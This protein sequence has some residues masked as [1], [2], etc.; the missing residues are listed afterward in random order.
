MGLDARATT[1][2]VTLSRDFGNV[3]DTEC[4]RYETAITAVRNKEMSFRDFF[5]ALQAGEYTR[6]TSKN[7]KGQSFCEQ[8]M[9]SEED[10]VKISS[11]AE[12]EANLSKLKTIRIR[13]V[14]GGGSFSSGTKAKFKLSLPLKMTYTERVQPG[15]LSVRQWDP[16]R[17]WVTRLGPPSMMPVVGGITISTLTMYHP[18]P[19]RIENVQHDAVLSLNDPSDP[20]ADVIILI[21]LKASNSGEESVNFFSK[22]GYF[23]SRIQ[24]ADST[25]G[26]YPET[27]IPTG[28]DWGIN[29]VFWLGKAGS[30]NIAPVTDAFFTWTGASSFTRT[31]LY[32]NFVESRYGWVPEGKQVRYFMLQTPVSI[33]TTD[34]SFLTRSLPPTPSEEAIHTIPDPATA[35]ASKILYKK[36]T[37]D[38]A[39]AGCGIARERMSNPGTGDPM[40]PSASGGGALDM[41]IDATGRPLSDMNS[42]DPFKANASNARAKPS[43]FTPTKATEVIF[44]GLT[45]VALAVGAWIALFFI[46]DK[47]YDSKFQEFCDDMGKIVGAW[48]LKV[49][50]RIRDAAYSASQS[51]STISSLSSLAKPGGLAGALKGAAGSAA[52]EVGDAAQGAAGAAS[53]GVGNALQGAVAGPASSAADALTKFLPGKLGA[54][55]K[56]IPK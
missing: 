20:T 11:L 14:T 18:S 16:T 48:M 56:L 45:F 36:A 10:A 44:T 17:G 32:S 35:G 13:Q 12:F 50:G 41:L 52:G 28:N 39:A 53:Q 22:I 42:C 1:A 30:D 15:R 49:N 34:L 51:M 25:T 38:A 9:F 8:V 27:S 37:G 46:M 26:L 23:L 24:T 54:F 29:K 3:S 7:S 43:L 5:T 21:P 6:P 19:L 40:S 31:L 2:S 55:A 4:Q 47:D 33:S